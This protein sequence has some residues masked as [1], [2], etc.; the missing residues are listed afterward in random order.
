C[1]RSALERAGLTPNDISI[2]NTHATGTRQGDVEECKAIAEVFAARLGRVGREGESLRDPECGYCLDSGICGEAC[3]G[4]VKRLFPAV[5]F[6]VDCSSRLL[7]RE[8]TLCVA[9]LFCAFL[10]EKRSGGNLSR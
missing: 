5:F 10:S 7:W 3:V 8:V 4:G 1:I 6:D 2:I 9:S